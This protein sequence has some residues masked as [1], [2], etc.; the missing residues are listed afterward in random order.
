MNRPVPEP[1]RGCERPTH[2]TVSAAADDDPVPAE[3]GQLL[4]GHNAQLGQHVHYQGGLKGHAHPEQQPDHQ[5]DEIADSDQWG[6]DVAEAKQEL[7]RRGC[8][9]EV[10]EG[11]SGSEG[12]E[13]SGH[14]EVDVTAFPSR[15]AWRDEHDYLVQDY[16]Q[17]QHE[18]GHE[19]DLHRRRE[20]L[21]HLDEDEVEARTGIQVVSRAR[22]IL[23]D[24]LVKREG[25]DAAGQDSD[26]TN[27]DPAP[28]LA[29]VV[30]EGE[31]PGHQDLSA[32]RSP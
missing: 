7:Q 9:N 25:D 11:N 19:G 1:G 30:R 26:N 18:S 31:L 2:S 32:G 27:E 14:E 12:K 24:L 23:N 22:Q 28:K 8:E 29:E 6:G 21:G 20:Q 16:G 5:V 17:S 4:R 3:P 15:Q 13:R 10:C